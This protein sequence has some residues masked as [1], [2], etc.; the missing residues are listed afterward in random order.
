MKKKHIEEL[1][2]NNSGSNEVGMAER[3]IESLSKRQDELE[4]KIK[5]LE[6]E[7]GD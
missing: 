5:K 2:K 7:A 3:E 6:T 4:E 1:N